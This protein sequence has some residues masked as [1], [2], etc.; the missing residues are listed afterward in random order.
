MITKVDKKNKFVSTFNPKTGFYVRTGVIEDGVD[1]GVDPFMSSFPELIDV[2]ISGDC[3]NKYLCTVGCYQGKIAKPH[4][5]LDNFKTIIDQCKGKTFQ[6]ALG[7]FGS[8]NEHPD[9]IEIIK[10]AKDNN[11]VPSYTTSGIELTDEQI[12]ATKDYCG[13]VAVSYY[14]QSYT[15]SSIQRFLE[16]N[17]KTNIHYV[18]G[19][20]SIDEAINL[21][22][23]NG[24]PKGINAVIF[25]MYKPVG[26]LKNNNVLQ[27][28][29]SRVKQFYE[30]IDNAKVSHKIGLDACNIAGLINF[31]KQINIDSTSPCDG[32]SF[33]AYITP[34]MF[35]TPCSFDAITRKYAVDLNQY[36]I[37]EAW[38][39]KQFDQFRDYHRYSCPECKNQNECRGNCPIAQEIN[40]CERKEKKFYEN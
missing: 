20:D 22:Q 34:D 8:P 33:S 23:T 27:Y 31:T 16:A 19:N 11:I 9:F 12:Q 37:Q 4:M 13:A 1:T 26:C 40:L 6:V 38:N 30:T 36:S 25:L 32:G 28:N 10:Y 14:R 2:G 29:D 18:I 3:K 7:G 39:S 5:T 24:F 17:I 35:L 15:Y 21:L